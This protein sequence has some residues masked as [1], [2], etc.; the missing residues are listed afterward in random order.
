[1][2]RAMPETEKPES[3]EQSFAGSLTDPQAQSLLKARTIVISGEINQAV[4]ERTITR[5]LALSVESSKVRIDS[6][7]LV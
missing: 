1:M 2:S 6:Q 3:P 4:A 5:L 7:M